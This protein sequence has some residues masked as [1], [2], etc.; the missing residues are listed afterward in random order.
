[1]RDVE[2]KDKKPL[3]AAKQNK[4]SYDIDKYMR[5]S[6]NMLHKDEKGE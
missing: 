4:P 1:M 3:S 6:W 5:S 2:A